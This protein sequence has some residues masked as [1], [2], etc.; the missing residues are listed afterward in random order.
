MIQIHEVEVGVFDL[1]FLG[2]RIH[3]QKRIMIVPL[4]PRRQFKDT[5]LGSQINLDGR[6]QIGGLDRGAF[7]HIDD[8]SGNEGPVAAARIC[9]VL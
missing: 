4:K 1:I 8:S 3:A 5:T 9:S 7:V 2:M 6:L